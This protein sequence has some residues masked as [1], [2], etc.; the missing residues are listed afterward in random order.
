MNIDYS[1]VIRTTGQAGEKYQKLLDSIV[2]LKPAPK[3]IIVVL[4]EGYD[5]PKETIGTEIFYYSPKGMVIQRLTGI[6]KCK[7][8]YALICDDDVCFDEHFVQKLYEP[9]KQNLCVFSAGPLYSFLPSKGLNALFCAITAGAVPTFFN[10]KEYIHILKSSGYSYNRYLNKKNKYYET[11][12]LPWT[13]FFADVNAFRMIELEDEIWLDLHGYSALDDQTMFYKAFLKNLKTYVVVDAYYEHL[14][15]KTSVKKNRKEALYSLSFNRIV[16]WHRFIYSQEKKLI[17][18]AI[19]KICFTYKSF[20]SSIY[21][22]ISVFRNKISK[23]EYKII[24]KGNKDA[25]HYIYSLE[26]KLLPDIN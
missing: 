4:P 26:Y 20:S 5:I 12:S 9:I 17:L 10:K 23:E 19:S 14:D 7:T 24:K 8:K 22:I 2:E 21:D 11:Q 3:D 1:V 15:G 16:F 25:W 13:C 6:E 18:R